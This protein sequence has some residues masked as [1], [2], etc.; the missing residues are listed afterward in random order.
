[1]SGF[2]WRSDT[3]AGSVF[4]PRLWKDYFFT[5][6]RQ[7]LWLIQAPVSCL[8]RVITTGVEYKNTHLYIPSLVGLNG[9]VLIYL[10]TGLA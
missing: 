6:S 2:L 5:A 3:E 7:K 10:S 4:E 8:L 1:M 9:I